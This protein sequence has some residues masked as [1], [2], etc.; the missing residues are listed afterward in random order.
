[1]WPLIVFS[2]QK[3]SS[4]VPTLSFCHLSYFELQDCHFLFHGLIPGRLCLFEHY[5]CLWQVSHCTYWLQIWRVMVSRVPFWSGW[6]VINDV[7]LIFMCEDS[8]SSFQESRRVSICIYFCI[9]F[10]INDRVRVIWYITLSLLTAL[11]KPVHLQSVKTS[12]CLNNISDWCKANSI[13]QN[14]WKYAVV[15]FKRASYFHLVSSTILI[16]IL[17]QNYSVR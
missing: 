2:T 12:K 9:T 14:E 7:V 4:M 11:A 5:Q 10:F 3:V 6:R 1:M 17:R 15:S 13:E 16:S 8:A